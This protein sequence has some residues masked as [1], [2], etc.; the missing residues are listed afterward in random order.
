MARIR[1]M[2]EETEATRE[3]HR[4]RFHVLRIQ[5]ASIEVLA[6]NIRLKA[7]RECAAAVEGK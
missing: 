2:I 3:F 7:L 5:S 4:H 1:Q 6:C